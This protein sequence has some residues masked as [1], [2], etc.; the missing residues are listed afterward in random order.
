MR[1]YS[2]SL[3]GEQTIPNILF[4]KTMRDIDEHIFLTTPKMQTE[5]RIDWILSVC[6]DGT[7]HRVVLIKETSYADIKSSLDSLCH[8]LSVDNIFAVN[9]TGGTK[10]MALAVFEYFRD[11]NS[12]FFY[13]PPGIKNTIQMIYPKV[14]EDFRAI[15]YQLSL[16]EYAN[17]YGL[18]INAST[19]SLHAAKDLQ[20][21]FYLCS[22]NTSPEFTE[23]INKLGNRMGDKGK[24]KTRNSAGCEILLQT[25]NISLDQLLQ[26]TWLNFIKG[27]WFEEYLAHYLHLAIPETNPQVN[28]LV[29][30]GNISNELDIAFTLKNRLYIFEAKTAAKTSS[31]YDFLYK[32]DSIRHDFGLYPVCFLAIADIAFEQNLANPTSIIARAKKMNITILTYSQL[33]PNSI[34]QTLQN[35]IP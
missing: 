15:D 2:V 32:I 10:I 18:D 7:P 4:I 34:I 22:R 30:Q 29:F 31:V 5:R 9:L 20:A 6:G 16:T 3:I 33:H 8:Q 21:M 24:P 11:K 13:L 35:L 1:K 25:L 23:M 26:N 27:G 28:C 17:A 19:S 14:C 12:Y